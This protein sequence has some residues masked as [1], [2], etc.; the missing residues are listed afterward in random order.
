MTPDLLKIIDAEVT[1]IHKATREPCD[2][3]RALRAIVRAHGEGRAAG[4]PDAFSAT[5]EESAMIVRNVMSERDAAL[6]KL[7]DANDRIARLEQVATDV[8]RER[9]LYK[10]AKAENDER[11][12]GE[13]D[14][15]RMERDE[16][17]SRARA[18]EA[19]NAMLRG[20]LTKS[21]AT[22]RE[23]GEKL[24]R[25]ARKAAP[26]QPAEVV[27]AP[28]APAA[29]AAPV[30]PPGLVATDLRTRWT[31]LAMPLRPFVAAHGLPRT[32]FQR[33]AAGSDVVAPGML[34]KI[35]GAIEK[36]ERTAEQENSG[37]SGNRA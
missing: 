13:R 23:M 8:T 12:T 5:A 16:A 9:D 18:A 34:A 35:A 11:F 7:D 6:R 32:T 15:A 24:S 22:I 25:R 1:R 19:E 10:R 21:D 17:L 29:P 28:A 20:L 26:V 33:W 36:A 31:A 14:D 30:V 37:N 3:S 4:A 2:R 27:Q